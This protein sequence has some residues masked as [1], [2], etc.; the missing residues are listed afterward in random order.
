MFSGCD[1]GEA[2]DLGETADL[3]EVTAGGEAADLG[4]ATLG[5]VTAG[6]GDNSGWSFES[7]II[8]DDREFT[9]SAD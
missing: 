5:G 8:L 9:S 6:L 1:L 3:G 2:A 4:E 7:V